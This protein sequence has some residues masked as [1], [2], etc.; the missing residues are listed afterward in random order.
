MSTT[1]VDR[2]ISSICLDT[3]TRAA[4]D[5]MVFIKLF[6]LRHTFPPI[7]A[8]GL[9]NCVTNILGF[10]RIAEGRAGGFAFGDALKEVGDLVDER[11][12]I[13]NLQSGHPPF[14]HVRVVTVSDVQRAPAANAAFIAMIVVL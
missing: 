13:T 9:Q 12:L 8:G 10:E 3:G 11:V 7:G 5:N 2:T 4:S 14:V 1:G 6:Q